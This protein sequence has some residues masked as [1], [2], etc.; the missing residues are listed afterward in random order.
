M[1]KDGEFYY[2]EIIPAKLVEIEYLNVFMLSIVE[3]IEKDLK[4]NFAGENNNDYYI[5]IK[6]N[7]KDRILKVFATLLKLSE[8]NPL[9]IDIDFVFIINEEFP[10][11]PPLIYCLSLVNNHLYN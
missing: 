4:D 2:S 10:K 6:Y 1:E 5:Y 8:K 11:I 9:S 7:S 3:K